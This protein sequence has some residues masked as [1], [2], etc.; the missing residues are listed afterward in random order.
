[1][2]PGSCDGNEGSMEPGNHKWLM[3]G[4]G[5]F[6][7]TLFI[8]TVFGLILAILWLLLLTFNVGAGNSQQKAFNQEII[9]RIE[10]IE[11]STKKVEETVVPDA[12]IP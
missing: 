7:A 9:S 1:M 2:E 5:A 4:W 10:E 3:Y 8:V 12:S 6:L 11:R